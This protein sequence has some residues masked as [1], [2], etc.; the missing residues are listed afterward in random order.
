[1]SDQ[2]GRDSF[3]YAF[4]RV[5][6]SGFA[7]GIQAVGGFIEHQQPWLPQ[8]RAGES[9]PL[10]REFGAAVADN[11]VETVGQPSDELRATTTHPS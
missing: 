11:R 5:E 9:E 3:M 8:E 1:M 6:N 4:D 2:D 10:P 7:F